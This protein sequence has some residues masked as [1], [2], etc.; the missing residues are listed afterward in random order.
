MHEIDIGY[1]VFN[2]REAIQLV[3]YLV[4]FLF[5][6]DSSL[7]KCKRLSLLDTTSLLLLCCDQDLFERQVDVANVIKD[8]ILKRCSIIFRELSKHI[9]KKI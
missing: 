1:D 2:C 3:D 7:S 4:Y 9:W 6:Y 8:V 5:Q